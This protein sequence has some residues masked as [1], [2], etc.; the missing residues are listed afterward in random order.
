V[1]LSTYLAQN[2]APALQRTRLREF[3]TGRRIHEF[4]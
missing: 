1:T 2:G 4:P 3:G